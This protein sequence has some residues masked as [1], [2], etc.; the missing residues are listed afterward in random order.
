MTDAHVCT[1]IIAVRPSLCGAG[2]EFAERQLLR[3]AD[4]LGYV[5]LAVVDTDAI[6]ELWMML[7]K[8]HPDAVITL[9]E[10]HIHHLADVTRLVDVITMT[11]EAVHTREGYE[12]LNVDAEQVPGRPLP[13]RIP[14]AS[15]LAPH[16]RAERPRA[17]TA[18]DWGRLLPALL[19]VLRGR[20][21]TAR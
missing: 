1:A 2:L 19:G 11:P 8:W 12:R 3:R 20:A 9:S 21:D 14:G 18:E 6:R 13:K 15:G 17:A 16:P 5:V 4:R 10:N 7:T